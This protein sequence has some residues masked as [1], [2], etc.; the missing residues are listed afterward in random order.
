[1]EDVDKLLFISSKQKQNIDAITAKLLKSV[2]MSKV[3]EQ[4][5]IV[6]NIRHFEALK[7][8]LGSIDRVNSGLEE[9]SLQIF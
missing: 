3:N 4:D 5:V 7:N 6:T 8:A 9:I 1:M 2:S